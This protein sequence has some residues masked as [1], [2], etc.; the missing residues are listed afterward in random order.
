MSDPEDGGLQDRY[1]KVFLK[2]SKLDEAH[3]V[4]EHTQVL[5][6]CPILMSC[7]EIKMQI[8]LQ[9]VLAS[10][11]FSETDIFPRLYSVSLVF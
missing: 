8:L 7:T 4:C 2:W 3:S 6:T 10:T 9:T 11:L 5:E 1:T